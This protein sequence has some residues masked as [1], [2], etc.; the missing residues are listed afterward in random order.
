[1]KI[2]KT[3]MIMCGF[4]F[5]FAMVSPSLLRGS[6]NLTLNSDERFEDFEKTGV[7]E[8]ILITEEQV[9][10]SSSSRIG[11]F[12]LDFPICSAEEIAIAYNVDSRSKDIPIDKLKIVQIKKNYIDVYVNVAN[13]QYS[14]TDLKK[15]SATLFD[16]QNGIVTRFSCNFQGAITLSIIIYPDKTTVTMS[17]SSSTSILSVKGMI[18][19]GLEDFESDK[20]DYLLSDTSYVF[21][22][23]IGREYT[24][25][26]FTNEVVQEGILSRFKYGKNA[27]ISN[28]FISPLGSDATFQF[29]HPFNGGDEN[30]KP[31]G[32]TP[33][34][35]PEPELPRPPPP[36]A[37]LIKMG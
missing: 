10:I 33:P 24:K 6:D 20:K 11:L 26:S 1:M 4:F 19:Q 21:T 22:T 28:D 3:I 2:K 18:M 31:A 30:P 34:P 37:A 15:T 35:D 7:Y 36:P 27:H 9:T 32:Y 13:K 5:L 8:E 29:S 23:N 17:F 14:F 25:T 16:D 12:E